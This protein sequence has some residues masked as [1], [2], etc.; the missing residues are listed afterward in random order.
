MYLESAL[1]SF[2]RCRC[3]VASASRFG[4]SS[5]RGGGRFGGGSSVV[6]VRLA[7]V[8]GLGC[9]VVMLSGF[10]VMLCGFPVML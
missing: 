1:G 10:A 4:G 3:R 9:L 8:D 7:S 5:R 2:G 6:I